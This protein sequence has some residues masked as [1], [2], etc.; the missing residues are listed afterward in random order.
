MGKGLMIEPT[1]EE[2]RTAEKPKDLGYDGT[3]QGVHLKPY[4]KRP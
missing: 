4:P 1:G 3:P 2:M